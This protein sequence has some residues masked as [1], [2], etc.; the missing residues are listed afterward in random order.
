MGDTITPIVKYGIAYCIGGTQYATH[1]TLYTLAKD[2]DT[3]MDNLRRM[4][5]GFVSYVA[6]E[7]PFKGE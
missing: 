7:V 2:R 6:F 5:G 1:P 4:N 3:D